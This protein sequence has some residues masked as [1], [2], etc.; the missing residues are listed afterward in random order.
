MNIRLEDIKERLLREHRKLTDG[1]ALSLPALEE[2][3]KLLLQKL[4]EVEAEINRLQKVISDVEAGQKAVERLLT[5]NGL[6]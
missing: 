3:R 1:R 5:E 2:E 4:K 6:G